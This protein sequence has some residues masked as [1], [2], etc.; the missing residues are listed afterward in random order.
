MLFRSNY[1][2]VVSDYFLAWGDE[3][4]LL[5]EHYNKTTNVVICGN[6]TLK[7]KQKAKGDFF[8]VVF[9]QQ[10]YNEYNK[11]LL[12][13]AKAVS[14]KLSI[15]IKVK[16]HP[17]NILDEYNLDKNHVFNE[18][19]I[20]S[21]LVII[22]HTTTMMFELM[23]AGIPVYKYKTSIPFNSINIDI[24]F[25]NINDLIFKIANP[26]NIDYEKESEFYIKYVEKDSLI[27]YNEFFGK[28][29][30]AKN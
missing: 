14:D 25:E 16:L 29:V 20:Y 2:N 10:L 18:E 3:T 17:R 19:D 22:G 15:K 26:E 13:I 7:V 12:E 23:R 4:K 9:D 24:I 28:I 8:T 30:H 21:S 1:K 11:Q 5:I 6:P 27:R